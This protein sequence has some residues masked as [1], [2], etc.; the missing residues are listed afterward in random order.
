MATVVLVPSL[1]LLVE[2]VLA[3]L[4]EDSLLVRAVDQLDKGVL[5]VVV[6]D[7]AVDVDVL[8]DV[9]VE[10]VLV[11]VLVD[12]V[13]VEVLVDVVLEVVL[14]ELVVVDVGSPDKA[15]W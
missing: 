1:M 12:V 2:L 3:T 8:V 5:V 9:L 15:H 6:L 11:N 4:R 14:L 13:L 7:D 10:G